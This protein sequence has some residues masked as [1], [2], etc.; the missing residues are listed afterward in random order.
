MQGNSVHI[1]GNLTKDIVVRRF[2]ESGRVVATGSIARSGKTR[3]GKEWGP[4]YFDFDLWG[5]A[6]D[7]VAASLAKGM[8]VVITGSLKFS[9]WKA[10]DGT[11]RTKVSINADSISPSLRFATAEV[12]KVG[13]PAPVEDDAPY[14][15]ELI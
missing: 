11:R 1:E 3:E 12:Q 9:E 7:H 10:Q 5:P 2:E 8:R 4:D 13:A 6:A 15:E 14:T